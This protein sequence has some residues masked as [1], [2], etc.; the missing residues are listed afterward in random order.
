LHPR[1]SVHKSRSC[2][3]HSPHSKPSNS[4]RNQHKLRWSS[5]INS[6]KTNR[7][8]PN[9]PHPA[10]AFEPS[11]QLNLSKTS[12][13]KH[14]E[15]CSALETPTT[16]TALNPKPAELP[17][18]GH[19]ST[20]NSAR[21]QRCREQGASHPRGGETSFGRRDI[22]LSGRKVS[23]RGAWRARPRASAP[24]PAASPRAPA[25]APQPPSSARRAG[26][27]A[28]LAALLVPALSSSCF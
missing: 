12:V 5:S 14:P 25:A 16:A 1:S 8:S 26:S 19:R 13:A 11:S 10:Q 15:L 18:L 6:P 4:N 21:P 7:L 23:P 17:R 20:R 3:K 2:T 9:Y 28:E 27:T 24:P 22:L